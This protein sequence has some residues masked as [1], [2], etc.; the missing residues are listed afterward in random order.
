MPS[1]DACSPIS[2]TNDPGSVRSEIA[3]FEGQRIDVRQKDPGVPDVGDATDRQ[4]RAI[5]LGS[6]VV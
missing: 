4:D 6:A 2:V 1:I 3:A 5:R